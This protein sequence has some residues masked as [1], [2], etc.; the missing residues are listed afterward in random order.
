V[1]RRYTIANDLLGAGRHEARQESPSSPFYWD[2]L[3]Q[4]CFDGSCRWAMDRAGE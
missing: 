3:S 1:R 4:K 2:W